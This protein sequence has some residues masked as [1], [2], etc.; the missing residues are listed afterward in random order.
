MKNLGAPVI[1]LI[2]FFAGGK[3]PASYPFAPKHVF[4]NVKLSIRY[5]ND[6]LSFLIS[7]GALLNNTKAEFLLS[8]ED[9][10]TLLLSRS[11]KKHKLNSNEK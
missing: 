4:S 1:S 11:A 5:Y 9:F 7:H 2:H 3:K 10:K 8:A 6:L